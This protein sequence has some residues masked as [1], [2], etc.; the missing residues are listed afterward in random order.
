[1]ERKGDLKVVAWRMV[2]RTG[3]LVRGV[4]VS[5]GEW[6]G[7]CVYLMCSFGRGMGKLRD[8]D[9]GTESA[10]LFH[11]DPLIRYE[12]EAWQYGCLAE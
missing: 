9:I 2:E 11:R 12:Y 4:E 5:D 1:M 6:K 8:D 10:V 3:I 7:G